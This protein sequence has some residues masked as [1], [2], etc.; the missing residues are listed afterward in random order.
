[1]SVLLH[2]DSSPMGEASISRQLTREFVQRWRQ[3]HPEGRVMARDLTTMTLPVIDAAWVAANY[4]P[5]ESRTAEQH[6]MLALSTELTAEVLEADEYVMGVPMHNWGPCTRFKLWADQI[7]RFGETVALTPAG[8]RG[9]LEKKRAT[10]C[11]TAG[12]HY[13]S[14]AQEARGNHL[15]PWLR[16]FFG[17]LGIE[18]M[19]FLFADGAADVRYGRIDRESY[20]KPYRAEVESLFVEAEVRGQG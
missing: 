12:R 8:P 20:L 13:G 4:T 19:R 16:T 15:V 2:V 3:A 1:M 11:V 5:K 6:A 17:Y 18:E 10:F 14:D 7:V 9:A